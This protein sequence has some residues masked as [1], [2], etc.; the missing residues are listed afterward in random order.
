MAPLKKK[1]THYGPYKEKRYTI[2]I[3]VAYLPNESSIENVWMLS[4]SLAYIQTYH[5][6]QALVLEAKDMQKFK[7]IHTHTYVQ[8]N[9]K[10]IQKTSKCKD[11]SKFS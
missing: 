2:L 5:K 11:M 6:K 8:N 7:Y 10:N 4:C 9:F 1:K 3:T